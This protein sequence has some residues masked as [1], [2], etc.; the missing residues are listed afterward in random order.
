MR[1]LHCLRRAAEVVASAMFAAIFVLFIYTVFM[2]YVL[3]RP[4]AWPDELDMVLLLWTTFIAEALVLTER[5]QVSFDAVYD[6][7]GPGARRAIGLLASALIVALFLYTLPHI[8]S[9]V[10]FLWRERTNV[11]QW[12]LDYVY[13]CILVYWVAV[14]VRSAARFVALCGRRWRDEVSSDERAS[15][16]G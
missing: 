4:P 1:A 6:L 10:T 11:L 9:Y 7:S 13:S 16:L 3:A 5:E 12:R 14:I 8:W 2:R 15:A